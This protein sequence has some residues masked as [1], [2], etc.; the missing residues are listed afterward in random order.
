MLAHSPLATWLRG[1]QN[2]NRTQVIQKIQNTNRT[3]VIQKIQNTDKDTG[4]TEDT[5]YRQ[6]PDTCNTDQ[7]QMIHH[8]ERAKL[9]QEIED[10]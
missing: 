1:I 5:E 9:I 6:G 8:P 3:Q 2:T 10:T 4:D 7:P